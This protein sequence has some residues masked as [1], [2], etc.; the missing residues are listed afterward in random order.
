MHG[1]NVKDLEKESMYDILKMICIEL[2]GPAEPESI[3]AGEYE[4]KLLDIKK[5]AP[6]QYFES[7]A[8]LIDNSIEYFG[9]IQETEISL[10]LN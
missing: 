1:Y 5:G 6:I 4:A 7:I 3:V 10:P 2:R 9:K 8:Y